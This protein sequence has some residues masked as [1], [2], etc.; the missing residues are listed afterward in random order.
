MNT[1]ITPATPVPTRSRRFLKRLAVWSAFTVFLWLL[2]SFIVAYRMTRR[3]APLEPQ[4]APEFAWG[5]AESL[6]IATSDG[7]DLGA[8]FIDGKPGQPA[9]LLL[10]G[11][12]GAFG[13]GECLPQARM[14]AS[15]GCPTLLISMRAHGD[16]TGDYDDIGYSSRHDVVAAVDWLEKNQPGRQ[17]VIFGQSKGAAA[18]VF[19]ARELGDRVDGYILTCPYQDLRTAV[20]NRAKAV[21]PPVLDIIGYTGLLIV[22]PTVLPHLD[23]IS[24]EKAACHIPARVPVLVMAG[25]ADDLALPKE[26]KAICARIQGPAELVIVENAGHAQLH[27]GNPSKYEAA[28][29]GFVAKCSPHAPREERAQPSIATISQVEKTQ[30]RDTDKLRSLTLPAR[31]DVLEGLKKF[32]EKTALPDGSFRPGVD[33]DYKGMSD[34]ALS[35]MAPVTYAVTLHKTLGWKLPHEA[36]TL[37][38]LLDRQK[39]DGAFYHVRGTGD[40]KAPL[41][42][43]YNTTQGL[44]ALRALGAR[45]KY[46]PIPVFEQVLAGDYRKLPLYTTSF[47]PLAYQCYGK[48]FPPEQDAKIRAI[49][50]QTED[51]YLDEH[52]ASTFH[53]VHYYR[54]MNAVTPK[55]DAIITRIVRDQKPDGSW[56][57]NPPARDRH[58]GFDAA[59]CLA[60]IGKDTPEVKNALKK[61]ADWALS[62]R[63][64]DGGFGH[65]PGSPSDAD[66]VYFQVGTLFLA[67]FLTL[68][69]PL[70]ME[71][72]LLSWGHVFP[73]R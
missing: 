45:P 42:R 68:A 29:L 3:L 21:L 70:P 9:V 66:A 54:L 51:G 27:M 25:G 62:C 11:H 58:A 33:P 49:M 16:S 7:Q 72:Q 26:A 13:R 56:M 73:R 61:A 53:L 55:A 19:A 30:A 67:G 48:P 4:P 31:Q 60:Q 37:A 17:I 43:V 23:E 52:V 10:H 50:P 38:L 63:N 6:R 71:P 20:W 35:D 15:V 64:P 8:W 12:N 59:F 22:S 65:F 32:W 69:E 57:L 44:V 46:D 1:T 36:K 2:V 18:A 39:E 47:F 41:T 5:N 28:L 40:P 24:P 14:F 34:S